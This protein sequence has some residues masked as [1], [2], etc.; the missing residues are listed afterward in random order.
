VT[1]KEKQAAMKDAIAGIEK[2]FGKGSVLRMTDD[3]L[4][5]P[6]IS[7][8]CLSIDHALGAGGVPKGRITE[9]F[10]PESSG[11]TTLALQVIAQAQKKAGCARSSTPSTRSTRSTRR[12]W[13]YSSSRS[14]CRSPTTAS[15]RSRFASS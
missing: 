4:P 3:P 1:D 12:S 9:M 8:G 10:G 7:T 2:Q 6:C 5:V 11:K 15:R 14:S 13:A